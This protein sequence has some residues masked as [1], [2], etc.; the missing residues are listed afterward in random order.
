M[1]ALDASLPALAGTSSDGRAVPLAILAG[2]GL[3]VLLAGGVVKAVKLALGL[4]VVALVT[5]ALFGAYG[6]ASMPYHS[7]GGPPAGPAG[8]ADGG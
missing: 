8:S 5:L 2:V 4:L 3:F 6:V 7:S 1:R